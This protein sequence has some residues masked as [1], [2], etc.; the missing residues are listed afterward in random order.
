MELNIDSLIDSSSAN[1][2]EVSFYRFITSTL[3]Q[4]SIKLIEKIYYSSNKL[5]V[6]ADNEKMLNSIDDFLWSYSTKHFIPHATYNDPFPELQPVYITNKEENPNNANIILAIGNVEINLLSFS[7]LL[8]VFDGNDQSQTI[9]AREKWKHYK[10]L[11]H[12]IN[13]WEQK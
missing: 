13:Y 3:A 11:G 4:A 6:I 7:K 9:F 2:Y 12:K 10:A 5:L 1:G 8:Y